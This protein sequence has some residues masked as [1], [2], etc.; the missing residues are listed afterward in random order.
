MKGEFDVLEQTY[1]MTLADNFIN[2]TFEWVKGHQDRDMPYCQLGHTAKMN[3]QAD[4]LAKEY[5]DTHGKFQSRTPIL[6]SCSAVLAIQGTTITNNYK[7]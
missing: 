7:T 3:V 1:M 4:F 2:V 5:N 6:P